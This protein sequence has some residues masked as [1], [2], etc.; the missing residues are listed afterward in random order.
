MTYKIKTLERLIE[1][2]RNLNVEFILNELSKDDIENILRLE[3]ICSVSKTFSQK[4]KDSNFFDLEAKY[5]KQLVKQGQYGKLEFELGKGNITLLNVKI[6]YEN[7][8][9]SFSSCGIDNYEQVCKKLEYLD[10]NDKTSIR[11]IPL[12]E[13]ILYKEIYDV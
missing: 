11:L 8:R 4:I 7:L 6:P 5:L 13:Y 1:L 9:V 2:E 12:D 10:D 3:A